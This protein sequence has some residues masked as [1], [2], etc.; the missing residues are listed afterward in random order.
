VSGQPQQSPQ[1]GS[2]VSVDTTSVF[3]VAAE[4]DVY[5]RFMYLD[6][7][8]EARFFPPAY[9]HRVKIRYTSDDSVEEYVG[10][11]ST[12][13]VQFETKRA[14]EGFT[15]E[16][17]FDEPQ[18]VVNEPLGAKEKMNSLRLRDQAEAYASPPRARVRDIAQARKIAEREV[19]EEPRAK[20]R[21]EAEALARSQKKT[22]RQIEDAGDAAAKAYT[23]TEAEA[24]QV[25]Q[26]GDKAERETKEFYESEEAPAW[27]ISAAREEAIAEAREQ[28]LTEVRA[29]AEAA[30]RAESKPESEITTA[31]QDGVDGYTRTEL[32]TEKETA[33]ADEA[34]KKAKA[35]HK[36]YRNAPWYRIFELPKIITLK[37]SDWESKSPH[38]D[39][40][41]FVVDL[42]KDKPRQIGSETVPLTLTLDPHWQYI[43]FEY[44]DRYYGHSDHDHKPISV[45][46]QLLEGYEDEPG[47]LD[48]D[49]KNRKDKWKTRSNWVIGDD[50]KLE[51]AIQCLPWII[52]R[53]D[54]GTE[55]K[56]KPDEKTTLAF[57]TS[58]DDRYIKAEAKDQRIVVKLKEEDEKKPSA[59]R[60]QYY[61]LPAIWKSRKYWC[62]RSEK[63]E[64]HDFYEEIVKKIAKDVA[65]DKK[66]DKDKPLIFSLDDMVLCRESS[67]EFLPLTIDEHDRPLVFFHAFK[68]PLGGNGGR[69]GATFSDEGVYKP[70]ARRA[71]AVTKARDDGKAK[72]KKEL[73]DEARKKGEADK[74]K[75]LE[76]KARE[77][78]EKKTREAEE[79]QARTVAE[80]RMRSAG[81]NE[82]KITQEGDKAVQAVATDAE[83]QARSRAAGD[84]AVRKVA[85]DETAQAAIKAA[86]D[87]A[88]TDL[89]ADG[90][91][92]QKIEDAGTEAKTK[93]EQ[94]QDAGSGY[95]YSDIV[96]RGDKKNYV[97][98]YPHWTR[99]VAVGGNL[100][101]AFNKRTEQDLTKENADRPVGA[102]VAVRWVNAATSDDGGVGVAP[103]T[104]RPD[105]DR[106]KKPFFAMQPFYKQDYDDTQVGRFDMAA[107][108]CC[109]RD[110]KT[111]VAINFQY[112][113]LFYK[114]DEAPDKYKSGDADHM[115]H[116]ANL[117]GGACEGITT[118][119]T[120][121][122][123]S[124]NPSRAEIVRD[125]AGSDPMKAE[126]IWFAQNLKETHSHFR[127]GFMPETGRSFMAAKSGNGSMREKAAAPDPG[128]GGGFVMAHE[129]G[130]GGSLPDEYP[131]MSG[132]CS[133]EMQSVE[134]NGILG[135]V[136]DDDDGDPMMNYNNVIRAR[137][138]WHAAEWWRCTFGDKYKLVHGTGSTKYEY[139]V[140]SHPTHNPTE[141]A[142]P[143]VPKTYTYWPMKTVKNAS[144]AGGKAKF[145]V[146]FYALGKDAYSQEKLKAPHKFDGLLCV[147]VGIEVTKKGPKQGVGETF[148]SKL[149][150]RFNWKHVVAGKVGEETFN[151]AL[152]YF[153]FG[154]LFTPTAIM[155]TEPE[156]VEEM[157]NYDGDDF[158]EQLED[159]ED[160]YDDR[161]KLRHVIVDIKS[162]HTGTWSGNTYKDKMPSV[163][164]NIE[165]AMGKAI[166]ISTDG[167]WPTIVDLKKICEKV[168]T[169]TVTVSN[170]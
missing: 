18:Y 147:Q 25:K 139:K 137:Y 134:S 103:G 157:E 100:H 119:W 70:A 53:S 133:Y 117:A 29:E 114:Y 55:D 47:K 54:D 110:D 62:Q 88:V 24:E 120:G 80:E 39:K 36:K 64:D 7:M 76:D 131:E 136:Y 50:D 102:R 123:G 112:Y 51:K 138:H 43:R 10:D 71:A 78:A 94:K 75:E 106:L 129:C 92:T 135:D 3:Q 22:R 42:K 41:K 87:K 38:Y 57:L 127:I 169:G 72:K 144:L 130:H 74:K 166:G 167:G 107:L 160:E 11:N 46:P 109:D 146:H 37:N 111:E 58:E 12:G 142:R 101:E 23:P 99:L 113:R 141:D 93:E 121:K 15:V 56:K 77:D 31:G 6:P 95:P 150:Q 44:F 143:P 69:A 168:L 59:K 155:E 17:E 165:T 4:L 40:A 126:I 2:T 158:D 153:R 159:Y 27:Y 65:D 52:L 97:A 13:I 61:D 104:D 128:R 105:C 35:D 21:E 84:E 1:Q 108:R 34:E 5:L 81:R 118:R 28:R 19:L 79:A 140:P 30:A 124:A 116:R 86:G 8:G 66:P 49:A 63:A 151:K 148:L 89:A 115:N 82:Q 149:D 154:L 85:T 60:L 152:I 145:D 170:I 48:A 68:K 83:A 161:V 162:T 163:Q 91:A 16:F 45:V 96:L 125:P 32:D 122:E 90:T 26:A 20:A 67:D 98:D 132:R 33:A 164:S 156:D 73:E 9:E 14:K